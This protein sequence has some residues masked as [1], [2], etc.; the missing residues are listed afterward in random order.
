MKAVW[1]FGDHW[2][3]KTG[4]FICDWMMKTGKWAGQRRQLTTIGGIE[5][6]SVGI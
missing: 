2:D 5:E 3:L 1:V 6:L 4:V